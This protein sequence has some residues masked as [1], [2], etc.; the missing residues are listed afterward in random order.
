MLSIITEHT[1]EII[2]ILSLKEK[3]NRT[4]SQQVMIVAIGWQTNNQ[5]NKHLPFHSFPQRSNMRHMM[6]TMPGIHA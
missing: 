6:L 2:L 5:L 4:S 3:N 1:S